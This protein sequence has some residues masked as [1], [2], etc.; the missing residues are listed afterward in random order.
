[1]N[2]VKVK[3]WFDDWA[4][5]VICICIA[6]LTISAWACVIYLIACSS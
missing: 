3:R 1:M 6:S 4:C 2:W 5:A